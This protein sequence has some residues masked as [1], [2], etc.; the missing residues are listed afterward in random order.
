MHR[1]VYRMHRTV[2][3]MHRT[4]YWTRLVQCIPTPVQAMKLLHQVSVIN[5]YT[6]TW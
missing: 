3:R 4:V 2:Y 5:F 6:K 1:T